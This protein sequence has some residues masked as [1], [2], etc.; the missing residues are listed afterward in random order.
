MSNVSDQILKEYNCK[1][2]GGWAPNQ[3]SGVW[4]NQKDS[5]WITQHNTKHRQVSDKGKVYR[6]QTEILRTEK[7][8]T[9]GTRGD[10]KAGAR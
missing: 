3:D 5:T 6:K 4:T 9:E 7:K 2:S 1:I 8:S 10:Q